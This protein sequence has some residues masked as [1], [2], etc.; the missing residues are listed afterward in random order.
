MEK[1]DAVVGGCGDRESNYGHGER[2]I[3]GGGNAGGGLDCGDGT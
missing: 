3:D 1:E 2:Y